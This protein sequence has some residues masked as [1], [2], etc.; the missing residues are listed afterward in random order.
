M[1]AFLHPTF[2]HFNV[3]NVQ[4]HIL[5]RYFFRTALQLHFP[6]SRIFWWKENNLRCLPPYTFSSN[7]V[8]FGCASVT[9][10]W[11]ISEIQLVKSSTTPL[12]HILLHLYIWK[13][14]ILLVLH[15]NDWELML[16]FSNS[17]LFIYI[18]NSKLKIVVDRQNYIHICIKREW[19]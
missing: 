16:F 5:N 19:K 12:F 13:V 3:L 17:K 14:N 11:W 7:N 9:V 1:S 8:E 2:K 18:F 6:I 4:L 10:T 15:L